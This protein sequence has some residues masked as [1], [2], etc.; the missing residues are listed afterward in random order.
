MEPLRDLSWMRFLLTGTP[1]EK[2]ARPGYTASFAAVPRTKDRHLER[3]RYRA[4]FFK[5]GVRGP[6]L[7]VNLESDILGGYL[8]TVDDARGRS[9]LSRYGWEPAYDEFRSLAL[10]EADRRFSAVLRTM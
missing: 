3:Y 10:E 8:L 4:F 2:V 1:A 7:A 5:P 9:V 6:V